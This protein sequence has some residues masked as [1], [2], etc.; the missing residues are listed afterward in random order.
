MSQ[1]THDQ[2]HRFW[3]RRKLV[4][5]GGG[6]AALSYIAAKKPRDLSGPKD[7]YFESLQAALVAAGIGKPT[8][9]VDK[10]RLI[11]N[12][13][14][15]TSQIPKGMSLRIAQKSVPSMGLL[16][17]IL[18]RAKTN[19]LMVFNKDYLQ[20][21]S[22]DKSYHHILLGKPLPIMAARNYYNFIADTSPNTRTVKDI[23]W[24]ID[25]PDRLAEYAPLAD[26]QNIDMNIN[27]EI[28]VGMHRGGVA[29][30]GILANMLKSIQAHPK[31]T[32]GGFMGYEKHIVYALG[33][34]SGREKAKNACWAAYQNAVQVAKDVLG[35]DFDPSTATL[36][37]G[38][39]AT[40]RLYKDTNTIN[41][42]CLGSAFVMPSHFDY[43]TLEDHVPA[44]YISAPVLKQSDKLNLPGGGVLNDIL[45]AWDPNKRQSFFHYGGRWLADPVYPIGIIHN[46]L[47][48]H[49]SN[50]EG[51]LGSRKIDL[52]PND[53]IIFRPQESENV[54]L[55]FG[56]IA[57]FED[58]TITEYWPVLQ[59]AP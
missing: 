16:N 33:G 40:Y 53:H 35:Q 13:D 42:I 20:T 29:D 5:G 30:L 43:D 15:V 6:L 37:G 52:K 10:K 48:G 18:S 19:R 58:G 23:E 4:I 57:V 36:N 1:D 24:L 59:T 49:S 2:K 21:L 26:A 25:T 17:T 47:F 56:D 11:A 9:I 39:S 38:G 45:M 44:A 51:V 34:N 7:P 32:F 54:F 46:S 41:D 27:I 8:L 31:L 14:R 50:Q 28:D 55:Q 12:I 3:T 22:I